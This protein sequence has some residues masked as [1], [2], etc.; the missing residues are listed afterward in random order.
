MTADENEA[1]HQEIEVKSHGP[2][3]IPTRD[4]EIVKSSVRMSKGV[5]IAA[6]LGVVVLLVLLLFFFVFHRSSE[7]EVQGSLTYVTSSALLDNSC[8][9][10]GNYSDLGAQTPILLYG[11]NSKVLDSTELGLGSYFRDASGWGH[12]SWNFS[13]KVPK[14]ESFYIVAIGS[15]TTDPMS[16]AQVLVPGALDFRFGKSN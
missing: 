10:Q 4:S 9:G 6:I 1:N 11:N 3:D 13:L 8:R 7:T 2:V 16:Y 15:R 5:K 12:C 14:G